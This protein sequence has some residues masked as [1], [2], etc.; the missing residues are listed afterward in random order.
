[1]LATFTLEDVLRT[2]YCE[3]YDDELITKLWAR[4][5]ADGESA[6]LI[7]LLNAD[8]IPAEDRIWLVFSIGI[9]T[10][11]QEKRFR[12]ALA[13]KVASINEKHTNNDAIVRDCAKIW[14]RSARGAEVDL[15]AARDAARDEMCAWMIEALKVII[16]KF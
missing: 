14:L 15:D 3:D 6:T 4:Y 11:E 5:V 16:K 10:E 1:M 7:D 13:F 12:A 2:D 8:G 9:I